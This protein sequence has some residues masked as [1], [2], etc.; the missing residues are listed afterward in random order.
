MV[1]QGVEKQ[2]LNQI[3]GQLKYSKAT[4]ISFASNGEQF[5][6]KKYLLKGDMELKFRIIAFGSINGQPLVLNLAFK[7]DPKSDEETDELMKKFITFKR[8]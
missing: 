2:I 6:G 5:S 8:L 7:K 4:D 1:E 3:A